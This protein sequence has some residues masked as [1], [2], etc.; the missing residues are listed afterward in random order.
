MCESWRIVHGSSFPD[1]QQNR[2]R[3]LVEWSDSSNHDAGNIDRFP[4]VD[5]SY[6]LTS[7]IGSG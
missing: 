5:V 7:C 6:S 3:R 4:M 2:V 1:I